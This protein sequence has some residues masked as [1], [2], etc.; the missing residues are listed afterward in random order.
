MAKTRIKKKVIKKKKKRKLPSIYSLK[1]KLWPIYSEYIRLK[2]ADKEGNIKCV[3]CNKLYP[4]IGSG[5]LHCGHFFSKRFYSCIM[6]EEL[7]THPV[8]NSCN[9]KQSSGE[10]YMY[11]LHLVEKFGSKAIHNLYEQGC[12]KIPYTRDQLIEKIQYYTLK[13]NK[14]KNENN[15]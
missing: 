9:R 12:R 1:R 15:K 6:F 8:C 14:L 13:L 4:A 7:N 2:D 5:N 11:Y 10:S 3:T